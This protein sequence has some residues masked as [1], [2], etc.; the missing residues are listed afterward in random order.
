MLFEQL[1][2]LLFQYQY[3]SNNGISN[4]ITIHILKFYIDTKQ[5]ESNLQKLECTQMEDR[6]SYSEF[7][8]ILHKV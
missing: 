4:W 6:C 3:L 5:I 7:L 8:D 2:L 1:N